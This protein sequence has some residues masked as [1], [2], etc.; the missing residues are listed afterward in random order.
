M[1]ELTKKEIPK[2]LTEINDPPEILY[3]EGN[4]PKKENICLCV[5]GSRK[6]T[7][8][9]RRIC[10]KLIS[11]LKGNPV[12]IISGLALG[13]DSIAH[14]TAIET[15]L[16]TIAV[17]GSGLGKQVLYP[18]SHINLA[19]EIIRAGGGLLSEYEPD[20][21]ATPWSFPKRNRIMAGM[22]VATLIIEAEEKSGTLITARLAM[23]YNRDVLA[24]PGSI[25][26]PQS[27]GTNHLIKDG[28]TPIT[29]SED[30]MEALG[31]Q[32]EVEQKELD[33]SKLSEN[34]TA[35]V[36]LLSEP[37]SRDEL[38]SKSNLSASDANATLSMLEIKGVITE[39][40]GKVHLK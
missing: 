6:N 28:A 37:I 8:Y 14:K 2:L 4:L 18:S 24:V 40:V 9:G 3:L 21:K 31:I 35:L 30:L 20:F 11:E 33:L 7:E 25:F 27:R 15:G 38:I 16:Q 34:E 1:R 29:S 22:S 10:Q 5:V 23:E 13:T 36:E 19:R 39:S 12:T 32:K 17:P 26:S